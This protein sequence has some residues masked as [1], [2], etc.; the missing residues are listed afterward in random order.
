MSIISKPIINK[1]YI[2]NINKNGFVKCPMFDNVELN[3]NGTIK[4]DNKIRIF[5]TKNPQAYYRP[6]INGQRYSLNRL[7]AVTFLDINYNDD[8]IIDHYNHNR[9]DND[10]DNLRIS[11]KSINN[12]NTTK[13]NL[14]KPNHTDLISLKHFNNDLYYDKSTKQFLV[15]LY[16][17]LYKIPKI[18]TKINPKT[19]TGYKSIQFSQNN[20]E[21]SY[22]C[23]KLLK[24]IDSL[25][26]KQQNNIK[27][28]P[29]INNNN[30][31]KNN[32]LIKL[33][34]INLLSLD[35]FN[36]DLFYDKSTK[37]FVLK[38]SDE[39]YKILD[40]KIKTNTNINTEYKLIQFRQN[41]KGHT[42]SC[43]K[44]K[45]YIQLRYN[46]SI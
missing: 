39:L 30:I 28:K 18:R 41:N 23:T 37:Q 38:V 26:N 20:I 15:K 5:K 35:D 13:A 36:N 6:K 7:M 11:T 27:N 44:L 34:H 45:N 31:Q 4:V 46:L 24:Y 43:N 33:N 32:N 14:T 40:I 42:Y 3:M 25:D 22:S 16:D 19:K 12:S 17:D 8:C 9:H 10:I 1:A 21:R 2:N 29:K